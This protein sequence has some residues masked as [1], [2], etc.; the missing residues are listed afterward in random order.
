MTQAQI[1]I[2]PYQTDWPAAY[3]EIAA[4]LRASA[5]EAVLAI[6]HVGSTAVPGLAA[7]DVI[8]IQITVAKLDA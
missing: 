4:K 3:R 2:S 7:K 5:G 6:H 8:D 1:V